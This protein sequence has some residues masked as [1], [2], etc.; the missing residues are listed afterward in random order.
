VV[1]TPAVAWEPL[2]A[3]AEEEEAEGWG[4]GPALREEMR[5]PVEEGWGW[6]RRRLHRRR[7][8]TYAPASALR[9]T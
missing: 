1:E 4:A 6:S 7:C 9:H 3:E 2:L 5:P 8:N